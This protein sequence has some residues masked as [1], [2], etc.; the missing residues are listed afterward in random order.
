MADETTPHR[1]WEAYYAN[2]AGRPPRPTLLYALDAFEKEGGIGLAVDLGAG[3]GRD[4]IEILRRGWRVFANDKEAGALERLRAAA[5]DA[6]DRLDTSTE[7]MERLHLPKSLLVNASFAL[8]F[9]EP[10]MFL[11][12]WQ[13]IHDALEPGGRFA[14][15]LLGPEDT[16]VRNGRCPGYDRLQLDEI[17]SQWEVERL[18]EEVDDSVTPQGE[19]KHWH[20]WHLNLRRG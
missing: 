1:N 11:S 18:E 14:G 10:E 2:T 16:W 13:R 4:A 20:L 3:T 9:I 12:L 5:G 19:A 17:L 8:P 7:P 6:A 15:Q